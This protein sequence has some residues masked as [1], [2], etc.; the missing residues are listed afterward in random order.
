MDTV[1]IISD[2]KPYVEMKCVGD[3]LYGVKWQQPIINTNCNLNQVVDSQVSQSLKNLSKV[4]KLFL[5]LFYQQ[6]VQK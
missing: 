2:G 6:F 3:H 4:N 1:I 5:S